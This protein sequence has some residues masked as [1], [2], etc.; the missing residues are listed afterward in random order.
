MW[1]LIILPAETRNYLNESKMKK[2]FVLCEYNKPLDGR[3][4]VFQVW[5]G[6]SEREQTRKVLVEQFSL[7]IGW[8]FREWDADTDAY[9]DYWSSCNN[10]AV[11]FPVRPFEV[12]DIDICHLYKAIVDGEWLNLQPSTSFKKNRALILTLL[13]GIFYPKNTSNIRQQI[14]LRSHVNTCVPEEKD[15]VYSALVGFGLILILFIIGM[16]LEYISLYY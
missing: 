15:D 4:K 8:Q 10:A 5:V 13:S 14:A 2:K 7:D 11:T 12:V 6:S 3:S 9:L 16:R 1:I